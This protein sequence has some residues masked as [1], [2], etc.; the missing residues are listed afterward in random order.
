MKDLVRNYNMSDADLMI[1]VGDF[2]VGVI[3]V[4]RI[5]V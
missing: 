5:D 1:M 2:I 4:V 3:N